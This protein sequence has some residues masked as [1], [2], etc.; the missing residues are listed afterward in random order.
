MMRSGM[1]RLAVLLASPLGSYLVIRKMLTEHSKGAFLPVGER[2]AAECGDDFT[3]ERSVEQISLPGCGRLSSLA[4][5]N[6]CGGSC[7]SDEQLR[8]WHSF[9]QKHAG[10][11]ITYPS[12]P[13]EGLA[14]VQLGGWW[15][16]AAGEPNAS[17]TAP[18]IVL[19]DGFGQ[20]SNSHRVMYAA[21]LL[22]SLG[23]SVVV[24]N[25]RDFCYSGPGTG[26]YEWGHA[27]PY[28]LAGAWDYAVRDPDGVMGGPVD[29]SKVGL[30]GFSMGAFVT[31]AAFGMEGRAPAAWA[32]APPW[33][34]E[35]AFR[36]RVAETLEGVGMGFATAHVADFA[37]PAIDQAAKARGIILD[38]ATPEKAL[39]KG[40]NT[41]RPLMWV[42]NTQDQWVRYSS[43][44]QLGSL[45][46]A[47]PE[48]YTLESMTFDTYCVTSGE[49]YDMN[50][51]DDHLVHPGRYKAKLCSFWAKAFGLGA[52]FCESKVHRV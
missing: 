8:A 12:R 6:G 48:K 9:N 52:D 4:A 20:T 40:P 23:F 41:K 50:H 45:A 39:R 10:T 44:Q 35:G 30:M 15:L 49:P 22:R 32:D 14:S 3:I 18:R 7:F 19:Q 33:T 34:P 25:F 1:D 24:N 36:D 2:D 27:Y 5:L 16:P 47:L 37:W 43:Q 21:Y 51:G 11:R 26:Y 17:Q 31:L 46:R 13:R 38:D 29:A 28:D 42:A